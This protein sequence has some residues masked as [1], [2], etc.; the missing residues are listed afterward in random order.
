[1]G[2]IMNSDP[3]AVP[4]TRVRF[5]IRSLMAFVA[6]ACVIL[7]QRSDTAVILTVCALPGLALCSAR[8]LW[9]RGRRQGAAVCFLTLAISTNAFYAACCVIPSHLLRVVLCVA[10]MFLVI[11]TLVGFGVV[12]AALAPSESRHS[13]NS[14]AVAWLCVILLTTIPLLTLW[15][16]WPLRFAFAFAKPS[17]ELLADQTAVGGAISFPCSVGLLRV[18]GSSVDPATG[19]VRIT[20]MS[21][22]NGRYG[23]LRLGA[24]VSREQ[25]LTVGSQCEHLGA[26]WW[27]EAEE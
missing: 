21:D 5:T 9:L 7:S 16:L 3:A 19:N 22:H 10:W 11:P 8:W 23:F 6:L 4:D 14:P 17:I 24:G 26:R 20:L 25:A 2:I 1:M 13:S 12:W 15:T 27:Y 18:V